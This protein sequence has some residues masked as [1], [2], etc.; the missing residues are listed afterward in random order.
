MVEL[1]LAS[2]MRMEALSEKRFFL[3]A[4]L[5]TARRE[6]G[7]CVGT[8]EELVL[9]EREGLVLEEELL[10]DRREDRADR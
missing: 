7:T 10:E 8:S 5:I 4:C 6:D 9:S 3:R 2:E 1:L